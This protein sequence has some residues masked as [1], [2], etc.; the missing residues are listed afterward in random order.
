M[1]SLLFPAW[2]EFALGKWICFGVFLVLNI[3]ILIKGLGVIKKMEHWCAPM[4]VIWMVVL[5]IWART[6]AGSWGPL[7]NQ[8]GKFATTGEFLAFF[9]V[10]LNA[11][12]SY[13]GSMPLTVTDFTKVSKDQKSH[14]VGQF[15]GIPTGIVGL[16]LVGSLVTSCTVVMFGEA[17]WDPVALTGMIGNVWLVIGMMCFLM[18]ATLTTNIAANALTPAVAIVHLTG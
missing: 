4:L 18:I 13:W 1:L 8:S 7:I 12:I 10:G 17:I 16:A 11:N 5:L 15:A 3:F 14:M 9:I 6:S 2:G